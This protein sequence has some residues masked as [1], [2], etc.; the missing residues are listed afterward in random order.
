MKSSGTGTVQER[1]AEAKACLDYLDLER[2]RRADPDF[3]KRLEDKT[4]WRELLE[5]ELQDAEG[6]SLRAATVRNCRPSARSSR[7]I[8]RESLSN[9]STPAH[10]PG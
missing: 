3:G 9:R 6:L 5:L 7:A 8:A 4:I 10:R 1:L 2:T